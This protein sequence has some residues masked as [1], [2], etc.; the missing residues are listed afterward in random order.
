MEGIPIFKQVGTLQDDRLHKELLQDGQNGLSW[1]CKGIF[2][3][4]KGPFSVDIMV[5]TFFFICSEIEQQRCF[6]SVSEKERHLKEH[7]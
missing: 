3:I 4:L 2:S 6:S 1:E 7:T 5:F